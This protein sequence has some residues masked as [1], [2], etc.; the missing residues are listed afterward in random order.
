MS[1]LRPIDVLNQLPLGLAHENLTA[2]LLNIIAYL[3]PDMQLGVLPVIVETAGQN[4]N[5]FIEPKD[6]DSEYLVHAVT[7]QDN[8][9]I[10]GADTVVISWR[11]ELIGNV[12]KLVQA[13]FSL[14]TAN[15][16]QWPIDNSG[17]QLSP[18]IPTSSYLA[19]VPVQCKLKF[20]AEASKRIQINTVTT[21]TVGTRNFAVR[22]IYRARPR[23]VV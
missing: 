8:N 4:V 13:T 22:Y 21:A 15:I 16:I 10:D 23:L 7:V 14:Y 18:A 11:D 9:S 3:S 2:Q 1:T 17:T 12:F 19:P 5:N 6:A 20:N